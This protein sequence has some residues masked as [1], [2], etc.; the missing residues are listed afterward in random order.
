MIYA[1]AAELII[2]L[3]GVGMGMARAGQGITPQY[4]SDCPACQATLNG[5]YFS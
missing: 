4:T 3:T 2:I 1:S 5:N